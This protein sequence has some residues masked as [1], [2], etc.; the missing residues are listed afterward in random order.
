[1]DLNNE[2]HDALHE[3][4]KRRNKVTLILAKVTSIDEVAQT[5]DVEDVVGEHEIFDVRLRASVGS[6]GLLI[7]P[8]KGSQVLIGSIGQSDTEYCVL[9]VTKVKK[10]S[11]EIDSVTYEIDN[12][13]FLIKKGGED[14]K[15]LL[16]DLIQQ[17]QLLTVTCA[18]PATPSSVP[19][20]SVAFTL[21]KNRLNTLL[22]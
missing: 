9:S 5:C 19:L 3:Y 4:V 13:G 10:L 20:N 15:K 16:S 21:I 1:M 12:Q 7:I 14:L 8:E 11:V 2:I 18:A 22:K 6:K 17:I